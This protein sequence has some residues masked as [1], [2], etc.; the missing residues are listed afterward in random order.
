M[1]G[2][3]GLGLPGL[4]G[5]LH[6]ALGAC[7]VRPA[8]KSLRKIQAQI[9]R[10]RG[11]ASTALIEDS[12]DAK[13]LRSGMMREERLLKSGSARQKALQPKVMRFQHFQQLANSGEEAEQHSVADAVKHVERFLAGID[14][15]IQELAATRRP[16]RPRST[17]EERLRHLL[18]RERAEFEAGYEIPDVLEP[19]GVKLLRS[20]AGRAADLPQLKTRRITRDGRLLT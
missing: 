15:E 5:R 18:E 17:Q 4:A 16:G 9:K 1:D 6:G 12:R 8:L 19:E 2:E 13:R 20:W 7:L 10:K 3:S 11:A 14:E